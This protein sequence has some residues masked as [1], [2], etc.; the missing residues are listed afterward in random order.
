MCY[1]IVAQKR[2]WKVTFIYM[3]WTSCAGSFSSSKGIVKW[4]F[5]YIDTDSC[6]IKNNLTIYNTFI[7]IKRLYFSSKLC[8]NLYS[9]ENPV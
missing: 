5:Q 2:I 9:T 7:K 4:I 3:E 6:L 1:S 8:S